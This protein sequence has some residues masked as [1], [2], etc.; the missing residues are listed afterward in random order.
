MINYNKLKRKNI[1]LNI[2]NCL[3]NAIS[4]MIDGSPI[5]NDFAVRAFISV[6]AATLVIVPLPGAENTKFAIPPVPT[7][8]WKLEPKASVRTGLK[9]FLVLPFNL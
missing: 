6:L 3:F 7:V 2:Y 4:K 9:I 8:K 1:A 5:L